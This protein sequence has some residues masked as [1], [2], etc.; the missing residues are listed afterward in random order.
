MAVVVSATQIPAARHAADLCLRLAPRFAEANTLIA[1]GGQGF[2][3]IPAKTVSD[4]GVIL[5]LDASKAVTALET[6]VAQFA[7]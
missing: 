7:F 3:E 4:W 2:Q 1:L 5:P 6:A